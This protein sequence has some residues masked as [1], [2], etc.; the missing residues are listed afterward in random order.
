MVERVNDE[1]IYQA[2]LDTNEEYS[3]TQVDEIMKKI[4]LFDQL[5][6]MLIIK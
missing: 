2:I 5:K 1:L 3:S 6:D 4:N